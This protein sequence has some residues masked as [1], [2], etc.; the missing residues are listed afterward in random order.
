MIEEVGKSCIDDLGGKLDALAAQKD[1]ERNFF[2]ADP[3]S[4]TP[5]STLL[6]ENSKFTLTARVPTLIL[7]GDSDDLVRPA[8]TTQFVR[9]ACRAGV[10]VQYTVLKG[11]GHGSAIDYGARQAVAWLAARLN[12]QRH[13]GNCR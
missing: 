3:S 12:G 1:L 4:L 10:P 13:T 2:R 11:R 6:A 7:Q 5:W 9:A 8:V